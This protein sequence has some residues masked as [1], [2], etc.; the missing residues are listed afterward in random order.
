MSDRLRWLTDWITSPNSFIDAIL[1]AVFA[2]TPPLLVLRV[3]RVILPVS[4]PSCGAGDGWC[5]ARPPVLRVLAG[6][7]AHARDTCK[8]LRRCNA[9]PGPIL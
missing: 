3:A 6:L 7:P 8:T 5:G 1:L 9:R 4:L 2:E